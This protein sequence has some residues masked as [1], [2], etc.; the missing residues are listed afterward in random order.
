MS[1]KPG[2][3]GLME[4]QKSNKIDSKE[5]S[6]IKSYLLKSEREFYE[7]ND[8]NDTKTIINKKLLENGFLL[9]EEI[10]QIWDGSAWVNN[11]KYSYTYDGN[12]NLIEVLYQWWDGSAWVN[13]SKGSFTYDVNNKRT[14]WLRQN[15]NG[16]AWEN[17]NMGSYT[18]DVNNN[19]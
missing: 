15:W 4:F 2:A 6:E 14:E 8:T 3:K 5:L 7:K 12:N 1:E 19:D 17:Y 18:N 10:N 16:S 13:S 9:E 11:T